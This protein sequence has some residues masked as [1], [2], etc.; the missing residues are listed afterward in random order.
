[1]W[2]PTG[3]A[4]RMGIVTL[5]IP[6]LGG[7]LGMQLEDVLMG[8]P[9]GGDMRG[10]ISWV[11]QRRREIGLRG[12]WGGGQ[13][14]RYDSRTQVVGGRRGMRVT[15]L[16]RGDRVRIRV[17]S[18]SRGDRLARTVQLERSVR[19]SNRNRADARVQRFDGRVA[20]VDGRRGQFG[21]SSGRYDYTVDLPSR[22]SAEM[23]RRIDR[24]RR[25][26]RVRFEGVERGRGVIELR[27]FR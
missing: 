9:G 11:D 25:G 19:D 26:D 3:T 23:R 6:L 12:G 22:S 7:C 10:E 21:L 16:R 20:W 5:M 27:R 4:R 24:M 15:D 18:R 2:M 13:S 8:G 17:D 1:M 14:V